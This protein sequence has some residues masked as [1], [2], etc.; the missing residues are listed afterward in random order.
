[1]TLVLALLLSASPA[2]LVSM[3]PALT[4]LVQELGATDRLVGVSRFDD[5]PA[6]K[7]LPRVGRYL[8]PNLEAVVRLQPDLVLALDGVSFAGPL[9]AMQA[10]GLHALA[11]RTD[12]LDD[13]RTSLQ[14]LGGALG[15]QPRADAVWKELSAIRAK[16]RA[17]NADKPRVRVAVAVGFRP[18]VL[19]GREAAGIAA[20]Q[21]VVPP[22]E[23]S[24]DFST[25]DW[26]APIEEF[27]SN[28]HRA[29]S[30][31]MGV[32]RM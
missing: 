30:A 31:A 21:I 22:G 15:L 24:K 5:A 12:T 23:K 18:L 20:Q 3:S 29:G 17:E 13:L 7:D 16:V 11:L 32:R 25:Y 8:D 6:L 26:D 4:D 1:M 28:G 2:R 9:Q 10:A 14:A 27:T 19:A